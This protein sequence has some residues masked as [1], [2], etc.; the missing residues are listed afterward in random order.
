MK[1]QYCSDLHL[2]FE[3]N[4]KYIEQNPLKICGEIL[5]LAGDIVP[6]DEKFFN[7]PFFSF[8]SDNY[9]NVFW[10]PG[11]HEFYYRDLTEFSS[12]FNIKLKSNISIVNNIELEYEN[13]QFVFSALWSE[14]SSVNEKIIEQCVADFD[15]ITIKNKKIR[16]SDFNKL[17][18]DSLKFIKHA[19]LNKTENTVVVTHHLPSILC[20]STDHKDSPIN[21]AFCVN[22]TNFIENCNADFWIYGHSH[23]NQKPLYLG[24]TLLL[25]NQLGYVQRNEHES[26]N[27]KAYFSI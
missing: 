22:L 8:I 2:E 18:S 7:H 17:H 3:Q 1:I 5:I 13:I 4:S 14:I 20:N 6:L 23:F 21:E 24:N 19:L 25:T 11:N 12:S 16:T 15:L 10:V 9:K 27:H 26:F